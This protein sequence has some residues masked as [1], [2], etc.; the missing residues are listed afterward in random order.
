[1]KVIISMSGL[2]S[3]FSNAGYTIPKFMIDIDG[4]KVI[5][6]IIDLYPVDSD[7]LFIIND[8]H[9]EDTDI[10]N[11]LESGVDR[12][13][14]V[15]IPRH[16]KGPVFSIQNFEDYIN[17]EE[18]T[19]KREQQLKFMVDQYLTLGLDIDDIIGALKINK[20]TSEGQQTI[21]TLVN[22]LNNRHDAYELT[23]TDISNFRKFLSKRKTIDTNQLLDQLNELFFKFDR[24]KIDKDK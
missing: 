23:K 24:T 13:D 3:R 7:F 9:A 8:K 11:L 5:E 10:V 18:Q 19:L 15:V 12:K 2:S 6:H 17:D 16:K 22:I 21:Q 14:I 20:S 1:M 4:K